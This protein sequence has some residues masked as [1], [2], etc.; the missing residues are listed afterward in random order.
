MVDSHT[1]LLYMTG[2]LMASSC[3]FNPT[4]IVPNRD[5]DLTVYMRA[6]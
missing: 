6:K 4:E 2:W 3:S 1:Q 5:S